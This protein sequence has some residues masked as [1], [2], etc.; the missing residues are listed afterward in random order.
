MVL[1]STHWLLYHAN[2]SCYF[3]ETPCCILSLLVAYP[4][5]SYYI[6]ATSL[7]DFGANIGTTSM[8]T[9]THLTATQQSL[10]RNE[11]RLCPT[12]LGHHMVNSYL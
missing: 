2:I 10:E 7:I 6:L 3:V 9:A 4:F 11:G 8:E 1:V 12:K 5:F